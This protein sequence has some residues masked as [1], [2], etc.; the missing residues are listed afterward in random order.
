MKI[1][2]VINSNSWGDIGPDSFKKGIGG[3][4]GALVRLASEW[5]S[6]GHEVTN[7]VST[8]GSQRFPAS[9]PRPMGHPR[10][11][12]ATPAFYAPWSK[13]FHEYVPTNLAKPM[14]RAFPYDAV[15]A[16]ECPSVYNDEQIQ[17]QQKVR[18]V[19][20]QVAHL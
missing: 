18:F 1:A 13:G 10:N 15:V 4:E 16:W 20:M 2:Q 5:A 11:P 12:D 8:G 17:E 3:R 7:F 6:L 9:P 19:H 14:L